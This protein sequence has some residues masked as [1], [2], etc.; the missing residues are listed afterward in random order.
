MR[1]FCFYVSSKTGPERVQMTMEETSNN[2]EQYV[3]AHG[4]SLV[5]NRSRRTTPTAVNQPSQS[6]T[7]Q[8]QPSSQRSEPRPDW[9]KKCYIC[10]KEG[11]FASDCQRNRKNKTAAEAQEQEEQPA[12]RRSNRRRPLQRSQSPLD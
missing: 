5:V 3:E 10:Q 7:T 12:R 6:T 8:P 4:G 9:S 2:A 11:Y 1:A